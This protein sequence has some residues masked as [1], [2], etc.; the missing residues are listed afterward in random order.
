M[1]RRDVDVDSDKYRP[2]ELTGFQVEVRGVEGESLA[3]VR[4]ASGARGVDDGW[5]SFPVW[6][7]G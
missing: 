3:V 4:R 1:K 5:F 6:V 7:Y 2:P